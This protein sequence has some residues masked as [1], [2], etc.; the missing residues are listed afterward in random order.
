MR[1]HGHREAT[2]L[3]IAIVSIFT[4]RALAQPV[5]WATGDGGNGHYYEFVAGV[6]INWVTARDDA[7]TLT[8]NGWD[9]HLVT[10]TSGAE[11]AF[12]VATFGGS[13]TVDQA[14]WIGGWEPLDDGVW[15]WAV[16][17]E[18]GIQFSNGASPTAPFNYAN[19][20]GVEPNDIG[21]TEDYVA[22]LLDVQPNPDFELGE[23]FDGTQT[24]SPGEPIIGY[25]VEYEPAPVLF[26]Q[27]TV[28]EGGNGHFYEVVL[29]AGINWLT[30]RDDAAALSH[31]GLPGHLATITSQEENDFISAKFGGGSFENRAVWLGGWEPGDDGVWRWAVGPEAGMQFSMHATPTAPYNFANWGGVEPND[32]GAL[33]DY[34]GMIISTVPGAAIGI[35]EWLDGTQTPVEPIVGYLVEYETTCVA[36]LNGDGTVDGADLAQLLASWGAS[37]VAA[38][39]DQTG[40]VDGADLA[41]LLASWGPCA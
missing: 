33:E 39:F 13:D 2:L 3:S 8:H 10:I 1:A 22:M 32:I 26:A 7:S 23:W 35:G 6:D 14:A 36:D 17:F 9:G 29:D 15:R 34:L 21:A 27:W 41:F 38:D 18:A 25:I 4:P 5:E 24:P 37:G 16:G 31:M 28:G 20:G 30:A 11:N 40:G 19:W 12:L